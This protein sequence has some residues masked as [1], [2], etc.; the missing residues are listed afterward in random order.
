[1][2]LKTKLIGV[3]FQ[4]LQNV[5]C[6]NNL[7]NR[8]ETIDLDKLNP[9][10]NNKHL[11]IVWFPHYKWK[12]DM[13]LQEQDTIVRM[14]KKRG[15]DMGLIARKMLLES[16]FDQRAVIDELSNKLLITTHDDNPFELLF[17]ISEEKKTISIKSKV[18]F[19]TNMGYMSGLL[20]TFNF[21]RIYPEEQRLFEQTLSFFNPYVEKKN[22]TADE[23]SDSEDTRDYFSYK[24]KLPNEL[25]VRSFLKV[26]KPTHFSQN[27][28]IVEDGK[29]T[30]VQEG[31]VSK[32]P[33]ILKSVNRYKKTTDKDDILERV[34]KGEFH[35][36]NVSDIVEWSN[37]KEK[38]LILP[39]RE[40]K[41]EDGNET[42]QVSPTQ[43]VVKL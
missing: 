34:N 25:I 15:F 19:N 40:L 29:L 12:F 42:F 30:K 23:T 31:F 4:Q 39:K 13:Y 7:T 2:K 16:N 9:Q 32:L 41:L 28:F 10:E 33:S 6:W 17:N 21:N 36:M 22:R 27:R 11:W 3:E 43:P 14:S 1:M 26:I 37:S 5:V 8:L 20:E 24:V 18:F 35:L 38:S